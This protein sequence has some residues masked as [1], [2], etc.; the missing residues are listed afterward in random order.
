MYRYTVL[1]AGDCVCSLKSYAEHFVKMFPSGDTCDTSECT[2][3]VLW[4]QKPW[5]GFTVS[6]KKLAF[7]FLLLFRL[8]N[9]YYNSVLFFI[10]IQGGE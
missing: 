6:Y 4:H 1:F 2:L 5:P 9:L 3:I 8:G 7:S 10:A